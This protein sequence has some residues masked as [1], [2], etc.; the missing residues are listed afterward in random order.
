MGP[1]R[2]PVEPMLAKLERTLPLTGYVYEPKWDGFRALVFKNGADVDIR[3]RND[4]RLARYFPELVDAMLALDVERFVLDGE[5]VIASDGG[6]DFAALMARL[7]PAASRVDRLRSETP[8][9]FVAFD[10]LA[11][12]DDDL[13]A[14]PF[15]ERRARLERLLGER[16]LPR[17]II[18]TPATGDP[19]V[20]AEWLARFRSRGIDGVVAKAPS[21][22]YSAGRRTMVKV[23][24]ERTADVVL[25]GARFVRAPDGSPLVSSMLLGL[26]DDRGE[27][28]HIGV[29]SQLTKSRRAELAHELAPLITT[30]EG[31]PWQN[32]FGLEASPLGRLAGS[33]GRWSP[34]EMDRDWVPLRAERV[35]E[36]AYDTVD[37]HRLRYPAR[38]VRW[39]PDRDPGSCR[40]EQ[41][42]G[43]HGDVRA[44]LWR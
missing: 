24:H 31:H 40:F 23:K 15:A 36:I 3:S 17:E 34:S 6:L 10:V 7:H 38:F 43:A 41:L 4:R 26:H 1:V 18:L 42:E 19:A 33:A 28:I 30:L 12:G 11:I 21:M 39:R 29:V 22:P 37:G 35:C 25:A 5:I 9:A 14:V 32:G 13:R 16:V 2:P 27:L 44:F 20:A 8:A